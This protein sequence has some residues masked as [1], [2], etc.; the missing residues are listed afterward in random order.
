MVRG[1]DAAA[2]S[3]AA[4]VLVDEGNVHGGGVGAG[5]DPVERLARYGER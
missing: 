3:I 1:D 5:Q 2:A 4:G